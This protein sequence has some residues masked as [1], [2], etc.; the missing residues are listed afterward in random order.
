LQ[1]PSNLAAELLLSECSSTPH[2]THKTNLLLAQFRPIEMATLE[3]GNRQCEH[4]SLTAFEGKFFPALRRRAGGIAPLL[5]I[6]G[7]GISWRVLPH[8]NPG[9][10]TGACY[11]RAKNTIRHSA[12][13]NGGDI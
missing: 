1:L 10:T 7:V 8:N 2:E 3:Q 12:I 5:I 13:I 4:S 6:S 9:P 11:T